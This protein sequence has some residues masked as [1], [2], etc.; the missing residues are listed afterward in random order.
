VALETNLDG[1]LLLQ[2]YEKWIV[3]IPIRCIL[4]E[5]PKPE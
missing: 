5:S 2:L 4:I 3:S 1:V